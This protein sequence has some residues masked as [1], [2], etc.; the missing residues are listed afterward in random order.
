MREGFP[1]EERCIVSE[2]TYQHQGSTD[3]PGTPE[4]GAD[5]TEP[6]VVA[7]RR[8]TID[9][10]LIALGA[11][12]AVVLV[13]A[14][15]LL[16]WG[17]NFASDYVS[18]ELSSQQIFFP[19]QAALEE[20]GRTDLV[21]YAGEQVTTGGQAEAYASFIGGHLEETAGGLT[22]AELGGPEREARA[23]V[24][25]A[26]DE[27]ASE[28]EIA[29]LQ[30]DLDEISGQRQTLFRGETLRGLLL[31]TYAWDTI[32]RIAGIAAIV[33]FVAAAVTAVLVVLGIIHRHRTPAT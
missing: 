4:P 26:T 32:G 9:T 19:D 8:R 13:I 2:L 24:Q 28:S 30:A 33:C 1:L 25:A 11:V 18:D 15:A 16:T 27:G 3:G 22:Y 10:V 20:E 14:G 7:V 21:K 12:A 6:A 31:S 29:A 17:N 23:A 5:T